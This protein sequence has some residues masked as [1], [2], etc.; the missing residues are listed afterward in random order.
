[1]AGSSQGDLETP[2]NPNMRVFWTVGGDKASRHKENMQTPPWRTWE[3]GAKSIL[4][5]RVVDKQEVGVR[6]LH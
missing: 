6:E 3:T 4:L 2:M 5:C 1:M